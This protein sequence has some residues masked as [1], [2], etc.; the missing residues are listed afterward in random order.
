MS[1]DLKTKINK[2]LTALGYSL[3]DVHLESIAAKLNASNTYTFILDVIGMKKIRITLSKTAS[4]DV[5][6]TAIPEPNSDYDGDEG[7]G[8]GGTAA[9]LPEPKPEP[10]PEPIPLV[11]QDNEPEQQPDTPPEPEPTAPRKTPRPK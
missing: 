10:K 3:P 4:G 2:A 5:S 6:A 8:D 11:E 1:D 7:G 9:P